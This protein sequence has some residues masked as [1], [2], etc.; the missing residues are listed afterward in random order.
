MPAQTKSNPMQWVVAGRKRPPT[1]NTIAAAALA[2]C[3]VSVPPPS[4]AHH[5]WLGSEINYPPL[6]R[7]CPHRMC[8][9]PA[10]TPHP[11]CPRVQ[12]VAARPCGRRALRHAAGGAGLPRRLPGPGVR[13]AGR[14]VLGG[15]AQRV[16]GVVGRRARV[17]GRAGGWCLGVGGGGLRGHD[18]GP[19]SRANAWRLARPAGA[20]CG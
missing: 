8:P 10:H 9:Q 7:L 5:Q 15:G 16:R 4:T 19:C 13:G 1:Y 18:S 2:Y 17:S 14:G 12:G 11:M 3:T 6:P 20:V